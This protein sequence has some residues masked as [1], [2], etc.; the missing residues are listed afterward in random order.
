MKKSLTALAALLL[1]ASCGG[2]AARSNATTQ[3]E[4]TEV[5]DMHNAQNSLDV[6][7]VYK[8]TLPAADCPGIDYTLTL[9]PD[10][11]YTERMSYIDRNT[12]VDTKGTYTVEGNILTVQSDEVGTNPGYYRVEEGQLRWLDAD[13][14]VIPGEI[15][16]HYIIKKVP[17]NG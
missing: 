9:T 13:K 16:E 5:A 10:G 12:V 2:N 8:G 3:T 1:L 14:E 4:T 6:A 17:A 7:G 15:G 11:K